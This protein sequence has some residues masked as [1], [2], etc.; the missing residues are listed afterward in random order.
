MALSREE[1]IGAGVA[2]ATVVGVLLL[3][4]RGMGESGAVTFLPVA[5]SEATA[6][7]MIEAS[8]AFS[9]IESERQLGLAE[10]FT[11]GEVAFAR[12]GA[13]ERVATRAITAE[14]TIASSLADLERFKISATERVAAQ[15]IASEKQKGFFD[16]FIDILGTLRR[17]FV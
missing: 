15:E 8:V 16:F 11:S 5:P 12:I 10:I 4:R 2:G 7:S 13:E 17:F 6:R 1:W 9:E 3:S 14:E